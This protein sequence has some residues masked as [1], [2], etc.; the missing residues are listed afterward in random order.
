VVEPYWNDG[1]QR[2]RWLAVPDADTIDFT[3]DAGPW[4]FPL[5]SVLVQQ[6]N[7]DT[8]DQGLVRLETRLLV[9][10][11]AGWQAFTY[12]WNEAQTDAELITTGATVALSV[13]N[14]DGT[15]LAL[16]HRVPS[17]GECVACHNSA[18]DGVL[19]TTTRQFN[20]DFDYPSTTAN[21]LVTLNSID[22]AGRRTTHSHAQRGNQRRLQRERRCSGRAQLSGCQ[23]RQLPSP[24]RPNR[25][26]S[27]S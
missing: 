22:L 14:S 1:A 5:G 20:R 7:Q 15:T 18:A 26:Q 9:R 8:S 2:T 24:K 17:Q 12:Q 10:T 3:S 19:G 6:V 23:L 25:Q 16:D 11:A 13:T 21:Q 27:R 4:Q